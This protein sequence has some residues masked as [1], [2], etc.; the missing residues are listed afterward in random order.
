MDKITKYQQI[1]ADYLREYASIPDANPSGVEEK[2]IVDTQN[3][4]FQLLSVGWQ[5]SSFIFAATFHFDIIDGKIWIQQNNTERFVA[6]ELIERGVDRKDIVLGFQ[7]SYARP[8][9]GFAVA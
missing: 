9:T 8:H 5:K 4:H 6:D 1:L 7:P 3:N 2:L